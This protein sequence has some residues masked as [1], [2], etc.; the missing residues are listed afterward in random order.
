MTISGGMDEAYEAEQF[1][2][3]VTPGFAPLANFAGFRDYEAAAVQ[4][5]GENI[6]ALSDRIARQVSG[7]LMDSSTGCALTAVTLT[8]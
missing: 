2:Q 6:P 8:H 3:L 5:T 1:A 7:Y 4:E